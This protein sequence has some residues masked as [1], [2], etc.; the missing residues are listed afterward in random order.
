VFLLDDRGIMVSVRLMK[1]GRRDLSEV[2]P[3]AARF[4]SLSANSFPGMPACPAVHRIVIVIFLAP[5]LFCTIL[6]CCRISL[7]R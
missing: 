6:P 1:V 2:N 5:F 3:S 7:A 4:A